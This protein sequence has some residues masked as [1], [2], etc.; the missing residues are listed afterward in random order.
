MEM[1]VIYVLAMVVSLIIVIKMAN[2]FIDNLVAVGEAKGISQTILGVTAS[3]VGTSLPEFGS[4]IIAIS[5]GTPDIGVGVVIGSNIWNIAGILGISA[6]VA[7]F[8]KAGKEELKRD[9]L[10]TLLTAL[11][12]MF[13]MIFMTQLNAIVGIIMI[14]TYCIYF[15]ILIKKQ[16]EHNNEDETKEKVENKVK[17]KIE[18]TDL[19]KNYILS[20]VGIIGL[21]I[22]CKIMVWSGVEI[23]NVLKV[24]QM[25]VGLFALS[26]GT[27]APELVV[28]LSSAMK[29]LHSLSM[30]TVLGSNVFNILIGI[31]V[32]SLFL[33][34]PVEPLSVTFDAPV[35]IIVTSLLL[36]MAAKKKK[37]TRWGGLVLMLIYLVYIT[38]RI[39]L[40]V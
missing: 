2:I 26:I 36:I 32:P 24:P 23:A 38:V 4:A 5:S 7:G 40:S 21:A 29:R 34:I 30:G 27:S 12:L 3:A 20:I 33:A 16:K 35:M 13:F 39:S 6:F 11:I 15:W 19:K 1:V 14:I 10:M 22:G 18:H 9:G 37:L 17:N 31:G 28:T 8:I 25:I